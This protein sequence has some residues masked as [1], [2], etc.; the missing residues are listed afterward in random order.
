MGASQQHEN[1]LAWHGLTIPMQDGWHP[2]KIEGNHQKGSIA[3]GDMTG[4]VFKLQW[5]R[6][7]KGYDGKMW[8][9]KRRKSV[10]G[11]QE[12]ANPPR[13]ESFEFVS[14]I[15]NLAIREESDKTVWWGCS[16]KSEVLVEV[17]L[18]NLREAEINQWFIENALPN[19][20]VIPKDRDWPWKIY[21]VRCTVP[22]GYNL[23]K[24]RLAAGDIALEF[25]R[26][27]KDRLVVRQVYPASLALERRSLSGWLEDRVFTEQRR[28]RHDSEQKHDNTS[29]KR[30][31]R[32][33]L[34]FPLGWMRP[35]RFASV[36]DCDQ[37]LDRLL[38]VE[39][40]WPEGGRPRPVDDILAS[41]RWS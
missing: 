32:K 25:E 33:P 36:I 18:T 26:G 24:R 23:N 2:L 35:K 40:E 7:P 6:P 1:Y 28:L 11:N 21:S 10:A 34:P 16:K 41:M 38:I 4:P 5:L 17:L 20:K 12:S 3:V 37:T 31:G 15:K 13:P 22:S 27:K 30:S 19:L 14:W 39:S 9:D 8:V 29:L